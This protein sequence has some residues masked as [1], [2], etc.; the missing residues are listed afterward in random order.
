MREGKSKTEL[1]CSTC[2]TTAAH[3]EDNAL[4]IVSR[5]HGEQHIN[6]ID[7]QVLLN[8]LEVAKQ[9]CGTI[10]SVKAA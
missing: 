10:S 6:R 1:K 3:I 2:R 5:H 8:L 7:I 4:V 9:T